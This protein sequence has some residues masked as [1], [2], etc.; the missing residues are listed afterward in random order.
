MT[1]HI[2]L[3]AIQ[4]LT[5]ATSPPDAAHFASALA[6]AEVADWPA[7]GIY[8]GAYHKVIRRSFEKQGLYQHATTKRPNNKAGVPPPVDVYIDDGRHGEYQYQSDYR[9]CP[10]IWNRRRKDRGMDHEA[11]IAGAIN[12]AYVKIKNRGHKMATKVVVRG[13]SSKRSVKPPI[14]ATGNR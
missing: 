11:P 7:A 14:P 12:Y 6:K 5:A 9:N 13:F 3:A 2:M 10:A 4:T 1:C 8:G